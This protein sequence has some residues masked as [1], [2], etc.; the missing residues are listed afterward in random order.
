MDMLSILIVPLLLHACA[1]A[2]SESRGPRYFNP[3]EPCYNPEFDR[4]VEHVVT[5]PLPHEEMDLKD[6]PKAWDWRNVNGVNYASTTRNQHIP[7]YC[8]SCWAMG[9]TSALADRINILR[10]NAF[11]SAFLS[12][13][14]IIDC[15]GAGSCHGGGNY[16]VYRYA[17]RSGIP[18]ETCN[19]YQAKDQACT[20]FNQ[21]GTCET[22]GKCF[23]LKN[24]TRFHVSQYG[25][26][27][28]ID[29]I[30]AEIMKRGPVSCG[31]MS[32]QKFDDYRGGIY[33]EFHRWSQENHILTLAGWGV[34]NGVEYWIGRNS[35]GEP[36][37][38]L[39][40]FRIVTSAF[41]GG[42]GGSYNLGVE[43]NCAWA[44]P[45]IPDSWKTSV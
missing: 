29:N 9:T 8:G 7:Q 5:G 45:V 13:Q 25:G 21:C 39:G 10:K 28:G 38:E 6:L 15:G 42:Q 19:N 16:G 35:W 44:V 34:E 22:F 37:G 11:P 17:H 24:Y 30:K 1:G 31:I 32:T 14:N 33:T 23:S 4:G 43:D 3:D 18:D 26:V 20:S 12:V 36:W 40:W 41:K 2:P 27:S